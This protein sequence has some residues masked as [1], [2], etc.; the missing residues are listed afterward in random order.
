MEDNFKNLSLEDKPRERIERAG[1]AKVASTADLLAI[2]LKTGTVGCNVVELANRL[3]VAFDGIRQLVRTDYAELKSRIRAY[4][5]THPE[6]RIAGLGRVKLLELAAALELVRRGYAKKVVSPKVIKTAKMASKVFGQVL[7]ASEEQESF[8]VLP[9]DTK[10]RPLSEPQL[11]S[12]GTLNGVNVHP[13][14]VFRV[15]VRWNAQSVIVAHSH[16][17]GVVKPSTKDVEL[18]RAL[19]EAGRLMGI[20]ML[21]HLI[22]AGKSYYSF[23]EA[24]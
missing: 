6:R 8:W 11:V 1:T 10:H 13:R 19:N 20:P 21:D 23:V 15:A 5:L 4:N 22:L 12:V 16:P 2:I 9:L 7:D 24:E 14:D 18:T 3:L 17:S